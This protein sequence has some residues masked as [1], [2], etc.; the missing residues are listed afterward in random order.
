MNIFPIR[1]EADY[2]KALSRIEMLMDAEFNTP[3]GDELDILTTL[4]ENYEAKHFPIPQCDPIEAIR[5][6][7]EQMGLEAKDLTPII[8]SRSKVSE[9][10]NHKRQ[11]SISMIR[12]LHAR[13][14]L[15]Y[16]SLIGA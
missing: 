9:V 5:F 1:T 10:L 13:L 7:M 2:E 14:N 16:E 6:R 8:G 3:E 4:V 11:L 12:N 15:P